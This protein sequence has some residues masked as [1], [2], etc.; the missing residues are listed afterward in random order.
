MTDLTKP[1]RRRSFTRYGSRRIV[2]CLKPG[3]LISFREEGR[4]KEYELPIETCFIMAARAE[5]ES[6]RKA[7]A[8]AKKARK[9]SRD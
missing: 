8:E 4:R 5:A 3:D 6:I 7:K 9:K 1:V 2:V